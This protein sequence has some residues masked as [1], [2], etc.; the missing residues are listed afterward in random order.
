MRRISER[1]GRGSRPNVADI[2]SLALD[3]ARRLRQHAGETN[4]HNDNPTEAALG[5]IDQARAQIAGNV[6]P[7]GGKSWWEGASPVLYCYEFLAPGELAAL[8]SYVLERKSAFSPAS[9]VN[10]K[11][12]MAFVDTSFRLSETLFALGPFRSLFEKRVSNYLDFACAR[13]D[14]PLFD[15]PTFELQLTATRNGGFFLAHDDNSHRANRT[16]RLTFV[17]YFFFEPLKWTGRA[18]RCRPV[19]ARPVPLDIP[20]VQNRLVFFE[21]SLRHEVMPFASESD[22]FEASRFTVN[23]WVHQEKWLCQGGES[24][25]PFS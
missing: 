2:A 16:R 19:S 12:S 5:I 17:Y 6:V 24:E 10:D 14:L 25:N 15:R 4:G 11:T 22:A 8:R 20:P 3:L 1:A 18:L 23:G 7:S 21:S 13:L 9:L